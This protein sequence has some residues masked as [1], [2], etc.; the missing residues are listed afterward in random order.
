MQIPK[1][2]KEKP[3][4]EFRWDKDGNLHL[5]TTSDFWGGKDCGFISSNGT[6][7]NSCPPKKLKRYINAYNKKRIK[8]IEKEIVKLQK[9]LELVKAQTRNLDF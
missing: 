7:G 4:I 3:Y 5:S 9:Q 1:T 2:T 8:K 6:E